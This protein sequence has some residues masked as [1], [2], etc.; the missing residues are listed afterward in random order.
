[1]N[2]LL[3]GRLPERIACY[4]LT[5]QGVQLL[6]T[7]VP[8]LEIQASVSC[9]VPERMVTG[10]EH[11]FSLLH[12]AVEQNFKNYDAHI[13]VAAAGIVVRTIAP[14]LQH[15][16]TDPCVVV[17]DQ[18]GNFAISLLSGH[19][20]GGNALARHVAQYLGGTPVITTATDTEDLPS[21][22]TIAQQAGCSIVDWDKVKTI[23]AA[24]L[25]GQTVQIFD[26][27]RVL[28]LGANPL[29][30]PASLSQI[31]KDMPTVS[32][33]WRHVEP[34]DNLLRLAIPALHVGVGCR[35]HVPADEIA[36]AVRQS[37]HDAGL[38]VLS[39]SRLASVA[40]K[41][42]EEGL[43]ECARQLHVPLVF[44]SPEELSDAPAPTPS[45]MA[46]Q[47]FGVDRISVCEGAALLSAGG[48]DS[49]L[50]LPKVKYND[51]ITVAIAVPENMVGEDEQ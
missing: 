15:K 9:F 13:F 10:H 28:T 49:F 51:N 16:S 24:L 21:L 44:Y 46:A 48:E 43:L 47:I 7:L 12:H 37:L 20:G 8:Q 42:D 35:R 40:A 5:N 26:P 17:C 50:L 31:R 6:R 30:S 39:V 29:F 41:Q 3:S 11:G 32:V 4:A 27:L 25:A 19:W 38:E 36:R 23:N 45:A 34:G 14:L 1:M 18:Q 22:D 2:T 33:H